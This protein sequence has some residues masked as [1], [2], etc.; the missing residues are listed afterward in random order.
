MKPLYKSAVITGVGVILLGASL[1][2]SSAGVVSGAGQTRDRATQ[3]PPAAKSC[4]TSGYCLS[5]TNN[6]SGGGISVTNNSSSDAAVDATNGNL[7]AIYAR[8]ANGAG[9]IGLS[10]VGTGVEAE[11]NGDGDS[12]FD[13]AT[14][15]SKATAGAD[16]QLFYAENTASGGYCFINNVGDLVCSGVIGD[17]RRTSGGQRVLTYA[18]ESASETIEDVGTARM[19]GGVANVQIDPSFASVTDHQWY[20][21]F[22]TPL[23]DS[24]GLY[25]SIQTPAAFQVRENEHGRDGVAFNYRIVAHPID[26]K[27]ARLPVAPPMPRQ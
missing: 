14:L 3:I 1:A 19:S 6:G 9:I 11:S 13:G 21:V 18:S 4:D 23:G 26:G 24:R 20:Y 27:N 2:L 16:Q 22:I 12:S 8:S 5:E 25:V 10:N 15:I 17:V 7:T